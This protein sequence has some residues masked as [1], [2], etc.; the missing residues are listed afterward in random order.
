VRFRQACAA[1]IFLTFP[2]VAH[3]HFLPRRIE[4]RST[5]I[6]AKN[7]QA[8]ARFDHTD[9]IHF[10]KIRFSDPANWVPVLI[11]WL[12]NFLEINVRI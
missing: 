12:P 6:A 5:Q 10:A 2:I 7:A 9:E 1:I 8:F 3:A 11:L 4:A